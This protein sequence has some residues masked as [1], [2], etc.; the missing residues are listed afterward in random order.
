M[1]C[2]QC[3]KTLSLLVALKG[4]GECKNCSAKV[5]NSPKDAV[6]FS[7]LSM[8]VFLFIPISVGLKMCVV[9]MLG[10]LYLILGRTEILKDE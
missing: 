2:C 6:A 8:M 4:R 7:I 9:L 10:I 3:E 5:I 1:K